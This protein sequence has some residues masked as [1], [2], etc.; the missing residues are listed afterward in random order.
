MSGT[1]LLRNGHIVCGALKGHMGVVGYG[2]WPPET[3]V[4]A[5]PHKTTCAGCCKVV[6]LPPPQAPPPPRV[7]P[8]LAAAVEDIKATWVGSAMDA[9]TTAL[10]EGTTIGELAPLAKQAAIENMLKAR[11]GST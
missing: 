2:L 9:V 11:G 5:N 4:T 1:H 3:R 8:Q 7:S 10:H 6:E